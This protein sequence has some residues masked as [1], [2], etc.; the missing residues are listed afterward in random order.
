MSLIDRDELRHR[1]SVI[2]NAKPFDC[3]A[4]ADGQY[5]G[6]RRAVRMLNEMPEVKCACE[7]ETPCTSSAT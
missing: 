4:Y 7:K 6:L 3:D 2:I 5:T 1:L